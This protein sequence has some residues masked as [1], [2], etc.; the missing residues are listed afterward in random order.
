MEWS[1]KQLERL[2][3]DWEKVSKEPLKLLQDGTMIYAFG[4]E[5]ACLRLF[6]HYRHTGMPK[7]GSAFSKNLRTWYFRLDTNIE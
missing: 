1:E 6:H 7:A 5:L 3:K 2:K 4:S